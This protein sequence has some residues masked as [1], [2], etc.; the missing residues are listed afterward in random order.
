[1]K[2]NGIKIDWCHTCAKMTPHMMVK[3]DWTCLKCSP[4]PL[5]VPKFPPPAPRRGVGNTK[6]TADMAAEILERR[7]AGETSAELAEAYG[8][9]VQTIQ[10]H[11]RGFVATKAMIL[12]WVDERIEFHKNKGE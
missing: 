6:I 12:K 1:M 11:V 10:D 9:G 7:L 2:N 5:G 3:K 8:V 4:Q